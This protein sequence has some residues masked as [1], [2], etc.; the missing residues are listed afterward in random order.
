MIA[1]SSSIHEVNAVDRKQDSTERIG[2]GEEDDQCSDEDRIRHEC[3]EARAQ[4]A[5]SEEQHAPKR[6]RE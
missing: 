3:D 5:S 6:V 4:I 2:P 1:P